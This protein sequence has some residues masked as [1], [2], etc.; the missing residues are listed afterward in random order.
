MEEYPWL[1]YDSDDEGEQD[2]MVSATIRPFMVMV[3]L[4]ALR[5][6]VRGMFEALIDSRCTWCLIS[7]SAVT[8]LEVRTWRL[9][10]PL[11]FKQV[12]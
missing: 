9:A 6:G 5:L 2:L 12:C 4:T 7:L 3:S 1:P 11:W 8:E 10:K